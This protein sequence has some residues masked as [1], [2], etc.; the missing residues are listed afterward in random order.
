MIYAA[1]GFFSDLSN[2]NL[3]LADLNGTDLNGT[4]LSGADL[5]GADLSGAV[6]LTK[7]QVDSARID[8]KTR[9]PARLS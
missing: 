2:A 6:N 3:D 5:T 9:L 7:D 4:D 1:C 8:G